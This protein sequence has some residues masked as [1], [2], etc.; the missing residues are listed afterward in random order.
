[1]SNTK[2][3][4]TDKYGNVYYGPKTLG[5][6]EKALRDMIDEVGISKYDAA[7]YVASMAQKAGY[8]GVAARVRKAYGITE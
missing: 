6:A 7:Y 4:P 2:T 1:M 3:L 5:E 8:T